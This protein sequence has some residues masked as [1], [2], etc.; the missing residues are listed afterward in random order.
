MGKRIFVIFILLLLCALTVY[1]QTDSTVKIPRYTKA[2]ILRFK[3]SDSVRLARFQAR[4]DSIRAVK[5]SLK[6]IG[7]S[8]SIVW[9]KAL[10]P[11]R[12]NLFID[13]LIELYRVRDINFTAWV[14]QFP[15]KVNRYDTGTQRSKGET[16][17]PAFIIFLL[18]FF[19][20]LKNA[21]SKELGTIIQSFYSNR[22]LAQINKE[23]TF[24]NSEP[25][26]SL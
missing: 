21:F 15:K 20:V 14:K 5:D 2:E 9:I 6:A 12:P 3:F 17:V 8:L 23:D 13:S 10:D 1:S 26:V 19:A 24:F 7:D 16:W 18:L 11:N 25:S 4:R 22:V